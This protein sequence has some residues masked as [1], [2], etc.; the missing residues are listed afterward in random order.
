MLAPSGLRTALPAHIPR[1]V[2]CSREGLLGLRR[3]GAAMRRILALENEPRE[4]RAPAIRGQGME[5]AESRPYSPGDDV[6]RIDW[7]VT[8]RTGRAHTKLFRLERCNDVYCIVDQRASM[9]FGTRSAYKS[10]VAAEVAVLA[11][12]AAAAG[13]DHFGALIAGSGTG[14]RSGAAEGAV[15]ALCSALA[16]ERAS[17]NEAPLDLLAARAAHE[18]AAGA[19]FVVVSDFADHGT[20]ARIAKLLHAR[21][22]LTLVWVVDPIDEQLPGPGRYP[23]TD[24]RDHLMLDTAEQNVRTAHARDLAARR[25]QLHRCAALRG[26]RCLVVRTG[27]DVFAA[28]QQPLGSRMPG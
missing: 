22:A 7:R 14:I 25:E 1:G 10:V 3:F 21:G 23:L 12:W 15:A 13:G 26:T 17:A 9:C 6:R 4:A 20:L 2:H 5:Y 27:A 8:A 19:R 11:G 18:A 16:V 24:G 28:L